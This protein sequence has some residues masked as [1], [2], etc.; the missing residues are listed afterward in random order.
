M[1][2]LFFRARFCAF[3]LLVLLAAVPASTQSPAAGGAP[4]REVHAEGAKAL[5]EAQIVSLT[6][7]QTGSQVGKD[8]LQAA[9]DR[10]VQ[11]GLFAKVNFNFLTRS[12]GVFVTYHVEESPRI[13][14]YFDNIPW[15]A[16]SELADAIRKT[17]PYF[18]GTLPE[19]GAAVDHAADAVKEL[20]SSHG[21]QAAVEHAVIPNPVGDGN[22]QEFRIEGAA[23][24]IATVEFSDPSVLESK[25]VQL[26]LSEIRGK[27]Y[28]RMAIDL[29]L[30]EAIRPVYLQQGYLRVKLGPPEV[31]LAGNPNQKF[32]DRIPVYVPVV[33]GTLFHWKEVHWTG[34]TLLSEFTLRGLL[35]VKSGDAANGMQL[36]EGWDRIRE[37]YGHFGY[38]E[39]KLDPVATF[40]DQAHTVSYAVSIHEGIQYNFGKI[41]LTGLSLAAERKLYAAWPIAST[42]L[43]DKTKFEELLVKLQSHREQVFG[44]LPVHYETVGHFLQT[45]PDKHTVDVLL[46]FK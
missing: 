45:D 37:E 10:L 11:S 16:D 9:A 23:P 26:H 28:S 13:P 46:D 38:L 6:G 43:F 21:M 44:E 15:F 29:F 5:T 27:A 8:D 31:R 12:G 36:E 3:L 7:L 34:N 41:V 14:V 33:P 24:Q 40:D 2:R 1:S 18:D 25:A 20:L 17:S 30:T 4:L 19:G 22:V 39:V 35:G 42:N 32:P